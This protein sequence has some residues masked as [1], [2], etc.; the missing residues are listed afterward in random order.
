MAWGASYDALCESRDEVFEIKRPARG[1]GSEMWAL[2]EP[3]H[4]RW[5][6]LHQLIVNPAIERVSLA[7]YAHDAKAVKICGSVSRFDKDFDAYAA[8]L[9]EAWRAFDKAIVDLQAPTPTERDVIEIGFGDDE[10]E[11][12]VASW[13]AAKRIADEAETSLDV[14]REALL[15]AAKARGEGL[16]VLGFGVKAYRTTRPGNVNWKA[17]Q[18]V[19]ALAAAQ[20]DPEKF[21][22][23]AI[24]A[25]TLR[26]VDASK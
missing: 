8:A 24:E 6:M 20:V 22:G 26:E 11:R 14:A 4:Y 15:A 18:I 17:K 19:A 10:Y 3:G 23:K 1:T 12:L 16:P 9:V 2:E 25:W 21:R 5:Q 7:V 13:L